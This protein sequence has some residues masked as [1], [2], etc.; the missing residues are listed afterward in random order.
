MKIQRRFFLNLAA[1]LSA[2]L[3]AFAPNLSAA[4]PVVRAAISQAP[5]APAAFSY[6]WDILV[7]QDPEAAS[8]FLK[9]E[10]AQ[11]WFVENKPE[12]A[13]VIFSHALRI[14]DAQE[15]LK[16]YKNTDDLRRALLKRDSA[17]W[18]VLD[19]LAQ[20]SPSLQR[21]VA[22]LQWDWSTLPQA[23]KE[24]L[25][26]NGMTQEKWQ[27]LS[28]FERDRDIGNWAYKAKDELMSMAPKSKADLRR[29]AK[30]G[31]SIQ[32]ALA[33]D[34][35]Q[36]VLDQM[37][38]A[39]TAIRALS[40]AKAWLKTSADPQA[41][42]LAQKARQAVNLDEML[43]CLDRLFDGMR[44]HNADLSVARP[45]LPE[46]KL[47]KKQTLELEH[48]L[49]KAFLKEIR[50]TVVGDKV[51][52]FY[53]HR[54][55]EFS[56]RDC[57]D[58]SFGD[59]EPET[60]RMRFNNRVIVQFLKAAELKPKDLLANKNVLNPLVML[61]SRTFIHE[62]IHR[63]Q[64]DLARKHGIPSTENQ[65]S[66]IEAFFFHSLYILERI[67]I[68]PPFRWSLQRKTACGDFFYDT[69]EEAHDL[70]SNMRKFK[71]MVSKLYME[72]SSLEASMIPLFRNIKERASNA[73]W[74]MKSYA[75]WRQYFDSAFAE[76]EQRLAQL[77]AGARR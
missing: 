49:K 14:Q 43:Q 22:V 33:F 13:G 12:A 20:K 59:Y 68:D 21:R 69:L 58:D 60:D 64:H 54:P 41:A 46:E 17:S 73:P 44:I 10:Q 42:A 31:L 28:A 72:T 74:V 26:E 7:N 34:D 76:V 75:L 77:A 15:L 23:I 18:R 8:Q 65:L 38:K 57:K 55:I 4:A 66:E 25:G 51:R 48:F 37:E 3:L 71:K 27:A 35:N 6:H 1:F 40:Q 67:H 32:A 62:T 52:K 45:E 30:L 39:S 70:E 19:T 9:D 24:A 29:M 63:M 11:K 50:G 61:L 5:S 47:T 53:R 36:Q 2:A 56:I 16:T